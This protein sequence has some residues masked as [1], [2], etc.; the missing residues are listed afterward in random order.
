MLY[1]SLYKALLDNGKT[2]TKTQEEIA[3]EFNEKTKN[4]TMKM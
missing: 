3:E 1:R 2:V 4:I